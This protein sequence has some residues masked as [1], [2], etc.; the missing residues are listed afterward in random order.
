[1]CVCVCVCVCVCARMCVR[2]CAIV[3]VCVHVCVCACVRVCDL[4]EKEQRYSMPYYSSF[5]RKWHVPRVLLGNGFK[6][7]LI[8]WSVL[9]SA[10]SSG[11][12]IALYSALYDIFFSTS[13]EK[14]REHVLLS[15]LTVT[16]SWTIIDN[17]SFCT[18]NNSELFIH[19]SSSRFKFLLQPISPHSISVN[20]NRLTKQ[21]M[22]CHVLRTDCQETSFLPNF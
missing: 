5:T 18:T 9:F 16:Q 19:L 11:K 6:T 7:S 1:M 3:H 20:S 8:R 2:A 4:G 12:K 13:P 17:F 10:A 14:Y 15:Q 22:T 21:Y